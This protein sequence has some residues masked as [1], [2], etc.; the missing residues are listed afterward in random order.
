MTAL[1]LAAKS[2]NLEACQL[3]LRASV[4]NKDYINM[5]DDGGWTPL[6]WA[7]EHGHL[8]VA[9][10]LINHGA[11]PHARDVEQNVALHWAAFSNSSHI[12]EVLL[13]NGCDVNAVNVHGETPL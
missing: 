12:I 8:N 9:K 10:Y 7:C 6:I 13:N 5:G 1:H 2:N 11:S 3:L 4:F